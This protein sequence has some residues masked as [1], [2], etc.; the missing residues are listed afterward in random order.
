MKIKDD[1]CSKFPAFLRDKL[2]QNEI[3]L[4]DGTMF[5]YENL[6][7]Y[8][9]VKREAEDYREVTLN[10]FKSYF[11]LGKKPSKKNVRA[12]SKDYT[13][14]PRYYG[15]STL[16]EK[17]IVEQQMHFPNPKKKMAFGYV[18]SAGGPQLTEDLHVCWWLYD[19]ADV[20]SFKLVQGVK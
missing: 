11:E 13:K 1:L 9:A 18:H 3:E 17:K 16:L 19:G 14:D 12:A 4:P 6:P 7:V 20:S 15:V 8:R 10:D 5:E 2:L